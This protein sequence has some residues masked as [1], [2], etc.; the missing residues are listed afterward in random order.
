MSLLTR[1][2]TCETER[3]NIGFWDGGTAHCTQHLTGIWALGSRRQAL[4]I[5]LCCHLSA[6]LTRAASAR[7][8]VW[9]HRY[10]RPGTCNTRQRSCRCNQ[11]QC[12]TTRA[13]STV[14]SRSQ[15]RVVTNRPITELIMDHLHMRTYRSA[16]SSPM[17]CHR[18]RAWLRW[19]TSA[20]C[21]TRY[22]VPGGIALLCTSETTTY[23]ATWR[24]WSWAGPPRRL[25]SL[26]KC[27][28]TF[29]M[30]SSTPPAVRR[31]KLMAG[32]RKACMCSMGDYQN[33]D[34][35]M[36]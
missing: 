9:Q 15:W 13:R 4:K 21:V 27:S 16:L 7:L 34:S 35:C 22:R 24:R 26:R 23:F 5:M 36:R 31:S 20:R 12:I 19:A 18:F 10:R 28:R 33:I 2:C 14:A 11:H 1:C 17:E 6:H 3:S 32:M 30:S 29:G 25:A 8:A